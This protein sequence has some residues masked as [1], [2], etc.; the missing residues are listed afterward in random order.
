M[1]GMAPGPGV[2]VGERAASLVRGCPKLRAT[3][4]GAVLPIIPGVVPQEHFPENATSDGRSF[5][6]KSRL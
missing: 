3:L 2:A 1:S 6:A 4:D 5:F